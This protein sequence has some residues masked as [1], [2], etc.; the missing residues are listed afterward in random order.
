LG[1]D[2][3]GEARGP[4]DRDPAGRGANDV[5]FG[6]AQWRSLSVRRPRRGCFRRPRWGRSWHPQM[7]SVGWQ[8]HRRGAACGHDREPL[9][10][11]APCGWLFP[12]HHAQWE[13]PNERLSRGSLLHPQKKGPG[14]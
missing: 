5:S 4:A 13:Q 6:I 8:R 1:L 11:G 14:E 3:T 2:F 10:G 12:S 9:G 7:G